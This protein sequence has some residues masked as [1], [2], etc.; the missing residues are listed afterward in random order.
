MAGDIF[1]Y[2]G[3]QALS[4]QSTGQSL[5]PVFTF[6]SE[7]SLGFYRSAA[8]TVRQSYGTL[9]VPG[10]AASTLSADALNVAGATTLSALSA[11]AAQF[12][13]TVSSANTLRVGGQSWLGSGVSVGSAGNGGS[14][15]PAISSTSSLVAAFVVQGSASSFT[16]ITWAA[17]QPG[18]QIL[19]TVM[20][21]AAVSSLSSGIVLHSHC[22]VAGQFEMRLS[23]VSTLAQ[24][25][26][27]RSYLFT[28]IT[29]F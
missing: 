8:S 24:N 23:N 26:S 21:S 4:A 17:V 22:T 27:S 10:L 3:L 13:S 6:S 2:T 11:T 9:S 20:Q 28:R 15:I 5:S 1:G 7:T 12:S 16:V 25:Q 18:D 14:L 19:T 29:P